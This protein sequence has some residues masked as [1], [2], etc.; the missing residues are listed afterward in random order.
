MSAT[1][2]EAIHAWHDFYVLMGTASATLIGAMFVVASIGS[3]FM[4]EERL[5]QVGAFMTSTVVHLSS[6]VLISGLVLAPSLEGRLLGLLFGCG[7]VAG[8][9]Y[10]AVVGRRVLRNRVDWTDPIWYGLLPLAA[11]AVIFVAALSMLLSGPSGFRA[12]AIGPAL[13]LVSGIR[14]SW[15]MIVY[16]AV[17][18]R[19]PE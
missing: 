16:F 13:L 19:G 6:V 1:A 7:G 14:N 5:P 15:D 4:V 17:R 9:V 18:D 8:L 10:C 12:L 2:A 3:R 11:Y